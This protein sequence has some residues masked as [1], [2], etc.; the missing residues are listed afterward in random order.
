MLDVLG[1]LDLARPASPALC[2][3]RR[4]ESPGEDAQTDDDA[5][6]YQHRRRIAVRR[7]E[8]RVDRLLVDFDLVRNGV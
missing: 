4:G 6:G 7:A 1:L 2:G 8:R 5:R 3:E